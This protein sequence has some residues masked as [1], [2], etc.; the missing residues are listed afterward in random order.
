MLSYVSNLVDVI[1]ATRFRIKIWEGQNAGMVCGDS[2]PF[3]RSNPIEKDELCVRA[4][5]N[6]LDLEESPP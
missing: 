4:G 6:G 3:H 5:S 1:P 2:M